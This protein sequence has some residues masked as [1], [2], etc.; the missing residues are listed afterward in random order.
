LVGEK[1]ENML[2]TLLM[3]TC[4]NMYSWRPNIILVNYLFML[5]Y[6]YIYIGYL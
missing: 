5:V 3:N 6:I 1:I 4:V 2:S